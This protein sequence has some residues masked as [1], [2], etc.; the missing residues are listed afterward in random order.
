MG[1]VSYIKD[2][3]MFLTAKGKFVD[4]LEWHSFAVGMIA[5]GF[6]YVD[7]TYAQELS[8]FLMF[9]VGSIALGVEVYRF[10]KSP[11]ELEL[12]VGTKVDSLRDQ[13]EKEGQYALFGMIIPPGIVELTP[14]VVSIVTN[15]MQV[16]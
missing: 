11:N 6:Y 10:K 13:I 4:T 12:D 3:D 15:L 5:S 1:L 9:A 16:L 2:S 14:V 7:M 8:Y